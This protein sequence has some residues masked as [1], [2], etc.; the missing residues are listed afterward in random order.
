[1]IIERVCG[2]SKEWDVKCMCNGVLTGLVS[3]TAGCASCPAW[4]AVFIGIIG[5]CIYRV[6]SLCVLERLRIDDPLDAFA[7]HGAGGAWGLIACAIFSSDYYTLSIIGVVRAHP[8]L[9]PPHERTAPLPMIGPRPLAAFRDVNLARGHCVSHARPFELWIGV[10]RKGGVLFGNGQLLGAA[11]LF[12]I[13]SVC[14]VGSTSFCLFM[15]L[16]KLGVLRVGLMDVMPDSSGSMLGHNAPAITLAESE[17]LGMHARASRDEPANA[18]V[19]Q[20][21]YVDSP[22]QQSKSPAG[23]AM[24]APSPTSTDSLT[25]NQGSVPTSASAAV[26]EHRAAESGS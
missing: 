9:A 11:L 21:A 12:L 24:G 8:P 25:A 13:A 1:M 23:I 16:R 22:A 5:G 26:E 19:A 17:P 4:A 2:G 7:V 10:Q 3:I 15:L 14:W 6:S 18:G 20:L